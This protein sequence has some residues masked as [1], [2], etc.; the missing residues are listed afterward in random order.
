MKKVKIFKQHRFVF[1][2]ILMALVLLAIGGTI[3]YNSNVA[4]FNNEFKL[5]YGQTSSTEEFTSPQNWK[6]CDET[7]KT[8][9][10]TNEGNFNIRVRLSYDEYWRDRN[11]QNYLPLTRNGVRLTTINFQNENDWEDGNDGWM[12]WK[13]VLA[14]GE[15]TRSLFRSVT[16]N[17]DNGAPVNNIC[18]STPTGTVC[19]KPEDEYEE[20]SYHVFVTVQTTDE[21]I[22]FPEDEYFNVTI[23]PNGGE[24]NGSSDTHT[25]R[26]KSGTR[27]DLSNIARQD[28]EFRDWSKNGVAGFTD[29]I[30]EITEDTTLLANWLS[31]IFHTVTVNPNGGT[32]DGKTETSSYEVREGSNYEILD[33]TRETYALE[34]WEYADETP[35]SG[36]TIPNITKDV[37]IKAIWAPAVA[38]IER[39]SKLYTSIMR[40]EAEAQTNDVITLLVDTAETVTNEKTVTLDLNTHT[41]TGS[42]TNT[43][44]GDITLIN[45]EINN[46]SGI[47]VTN[48][49]TLTMGVNDYKQ[50]GTVNIIND[51]VRLIGTTTG[52]KQNGVFNYYDGYLEGD[53]GLE[54]GYDDAP[55]YRNTFDQVVVHYF[56]LVD[57]I[58]DTERQHVE[59]ANADLA[60]SKTTIGGDIYYYNLQDNINTSARTGYQIYIVRDFPASYSILSREDTSVDID[61]VGYTISTG[62]NITINGELNITDSGSEADPTIKGKITAR[63]AIT[64]NEH[65]T[66]NLDD[67]EMQEITSNTLLYNYGEVNLTN[68]AVL[69]STDGYVFSITDNEKLPNID[70]NSLITSSSTSKAT[71]YISK[72][73]YEINFSGTIESTRYCAI[74]LESATVSFT[75]GTI[76]ASD[77]A[78]QAIYAYYSTIVID[79]GNAV[80]DVP[81]GGSTIY[82][83][84]TLKSGTITANGG[85]GVNAISRC[86]TAII[87]SGSVTAY[88]SG[89]NV[90]AINCTNATI[91]GGTI[92]STSDN[93]TSTGVYAATN[94][95]I[96]GGSV[97]STGKGNTNGLTGEKNSIVNGNAVIYAESTGSG[98]VRAIAN[99]HSVINGG[100]ITA[101]A[102]SGEAIGVYAWDWG[103]LNVTGG[104]ITSTSVSGTAIGARTDGNGNA[105]ANIITGGTIYGSTYGVVSNGQTT[106]IGDNDGNIDTASPDITG[107][108]Y[109]L[110][111]SSFYF[112][113]GILRGGTN[114]YATDV[115]KAIPDGTTYNITTAD[116]MENC[117]LKAGEN[118]LEVDGVEYNSLTAA[119]AAAGDGGTIKVIKSTTIVAD[120]PTN[121]AN[122][123]VY[124]DLNGHTLS[125]SKSLSNAGTF[126]ILDSSAGANGVLRNADT[127]AV[128]YN[129]NGTI[130][131]LS[132]TILA[133]N[134]VA[135]Q[136]TEYNNST[137]NITGGLVKAV[138]NATGAINEGYINIDGGR[139]VADN[140][141]GTYAIAGAVTLKSGSIEATK[142]GN[143]SAIVGA[144]ADTNSIQG[145]TITVHATSGTATGISGNSVTM[146][147]GTITVTSDNG[148]ANGFTAATTMSGGTLTVTGTGNVNGVYESNATISG[149]AVIYAESTGSGYVRAIANYHSVINGGTIT[150]K[151]NSGD[152]IGVYAW[153]WGRLTMSDGTITATSDTGT[154]TGVYSEARERDGN[155]DVITGGTI[156]GS[157][158]GLVTGTTWA[159]GTTIMR[160]GADDS[161]LDN[162]TPDITGGSYGLYGKNFYFYDGVIRGSI[163]AYQTGVIKSIPEHTTMY[164]GSATIDGATYEE[165]YLIAEYDVAKIGNTKYKALSYAIDAATTND[166]IELIDNNYIFFALNIPADKDITIETNGYTII[167]SSPITNSGK[168]KLINSNAV[169]NPVLKY[170]NS[171][172]F[173]QNKSGAELEIVNIPITSAK[174]IDNAG[175]LSLDNVTINS[176]D[177]A[178]QTSGDLTTDNS[179][180]ING[181]NYSIYS[182]GSNTIDITDTTLSSKA[183]YYQNSAD[184]STIT[185]STISGP[186]VNKA[187]KATFLRS[188]ISHGGNNVRN[189]IQN[190]GTGEMIFDDSTVTLTH[191]TLTCYQCVGSNSLAITNSNKMTIK[192]STIT[193]TFAGENSDSNYTIRS[194]GSEL[195]IDNS[196]I[197]SHTNGNSLYNYRY[198]IHTSSNTTIND[199]TI[200]IDDG[201]AYGIYNTSSSILITGTSLIDATGNYNDSYGIYN[202]SGNITL[203]VAEPSTSP[204]WGKDTADVSTTNPAV[205]GISS[206]GTG[207]GIKSVSGGLYFYDGRITGSTTAMPDTPAGVEYVYE[208]R[209]YT[210]A[211]NYQYTILVWMRS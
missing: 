109:G 156:Y 143:I 32:Y 198:A 21:D 191:D 112:Y 187:G 66:L 61:L 135:I 35:V 20:A 33:A 62:E 13:G 150:A 3:A 126:N 31:N 169:D 211:D 142:N 200:S 89:G 6:T 93:G 121:P 139:V 30:I 184:E 38:R 36:N 49:G 83:N 196:T 141:S 127:A 23:N 105:G 153:D 96:S 210:D 5:K 175:T 2:V 53:V 79:G 151:A 120:L 115:I 94:A 114:A 59:L 110:Y 113:D 138:E 8:V 58:G 163:S 181:T 81:G 199:S 107:G 172:F 180:V 188:S 149:N 106:T 129:N 18:H 177:I 176:S 24:F 90:T 42:L 86:D 72:N 174:A 76:K 95:T 201:S 165:Q 108:Q 41:I 26:V 192:D 111:G 45:G 25:D 16:Y 158:Y 63:K 123:T 125:Y 168:V 208:P 197:T 47:A 74:H 117:T 137:V 57:H 157:T 134:N 182:N 130:N 183:P 179:T 65:G 104:T 71:G 43:A 84:T 85:G 34:G 19:E 44:T 145:G 60:V 171:E 48:N 186:V 136:N 39:T 40:A 54:G 97:T 185:D 203:G 37:S 170:T 167:E 15:S 118:Y 98:Y 99:Y 207:T 152:A 140:I 133:S 119:Y 51:N 10:T 144:R 148:A 122:N 205:R 178:V 194:T 102:N 131:V 75:G 173:I 92:T 190:S 100:T 189:I 132:G 202:E 87:E 146:T 29:R 52:I 193:E 70:S 14:P 78:S 68:G 88:S 1:P 159:N 128:I 209:F 69:S 204:D 161:T 64:V 124:F 80:L 147:G 4:I 116:N 73:N 103:H 162:S 7:P 50:D 9:V 206:N 160:I 67:A 56:P 27:I 22:P 17:C 11:D 164:I 46:P 12:Y 82:G 166:T 55:V 28:F 77:S 101:K 195:N 155:I 154:A 91:T